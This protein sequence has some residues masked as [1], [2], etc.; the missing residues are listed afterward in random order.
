MER[1]GE[2]IYTQT[3]FT[4]QEFRS[5]LNLRYTDSEDRT[6]LRENAANV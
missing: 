6:Q 2:H 1:D 4:Q 5:E 3:G